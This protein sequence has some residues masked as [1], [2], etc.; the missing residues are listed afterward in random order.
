VLCIQCANKQ[1][2]STIGIRGTARDKWYLNPL[3]S[4]H[5]P[6]KDSTTMSESVEERSKEEEETGTL[7]FMN[8]YEQKNTFISFHMNQNPLHVGS[9][10]CKR[11]DFAC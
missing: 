9:G 8:A 4:K 2:T 5:H 10:S 3:L 6:L 11:P 7:Q 1:W